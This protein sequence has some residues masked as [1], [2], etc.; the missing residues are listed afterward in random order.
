MKRDSQLRQSI[1]E[2]TA[3]N[4]R[5]VDTF[6]HLVTAIDEIIIQPIRTARAQ[7]ELMASHGLLV[8]VRRCAR[9]FSRYCIIAVGRFDNGG[10]EL[11][12]EF[13]PRF[14]DFFD[15][16]I[17]ARIMVA[18]VDAILIDCGRCAQYP[19]RIEELDGVTGPSQMNRRCGAV[20]PRASYGDPCSH[21]TDFAISSES[22]PQLPPGISPNTGR[23]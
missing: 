8:H 4:L 16:F 11:A 9:S 20:N 10:T 17:T 5:V 21:V 3:Q 6:V 2:K 14:T 1:R 18:C 7:G 19:Q 13:A 15:G 22:P 12:D 23:D